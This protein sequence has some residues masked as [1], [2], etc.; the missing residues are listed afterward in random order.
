MRVNYKTFV[1][2]EVHHNIRHATIGKEFVEFDCKRRLYRR[3]G[4]VS[5]L[6]NAKHDAVCYS[7]GVY[8]LN[9][10]LFNTLGDLWKG[11]PQLEILVPELSDKPLKYVPGTRYLLGPAKRVYCFEAYIG[12]KGV[13]MIDIV[14]AAVVHGTTKYKLWWDYKLARSGLVKLRREH[15][16]ELKAKQLK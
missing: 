15:I 16:R 8:G 12:K 13:G 5:K 3:K 4:K 1:V 9:Y 2:K 6:N 10:E 7:V 11:Q 14:P